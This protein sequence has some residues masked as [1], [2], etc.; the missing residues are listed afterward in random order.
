MKTIL[1]VLS[2]LV[3]AGCVVVPT[4]HGYVMEPAAP[5]YYAAP[6]PYVVVAPPVYGYHHR[7]W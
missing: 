3:L 1:F 4:R 7:G 2:A 5:T 6:S